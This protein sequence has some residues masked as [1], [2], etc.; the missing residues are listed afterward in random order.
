MQVN[1]LATYTE[2]NHEYILS[3]PAVVVHSADWLHL[4][5]LLHAEDALS[6]SSLRIY[7]CQSLKQLLKT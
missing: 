6:A 5:T 1:V 3:D 4:N 7:T 2:S